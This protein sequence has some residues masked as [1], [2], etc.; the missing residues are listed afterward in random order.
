MMKEFIIEAL[1]KTIGEDEAIVCAREFINSFGDDEKKIKDAIDRR[2]LSEPLQYIIGEWDFYNCTFRLGDG[3]LCPRP[4]TEMLVD[5]ALDFIGDG[6]S[7]VLDLC[8]GSGAIAISVAKNA[9]DSKVI[10][11]EK[12]PA[13]Y[14]YL[15]QNIALNGVKNVKVFNDDILTGCDYFFKAKAPAF[16]LILSN[17]PYVRTGDIDDLDLEVQ[18]EPRLAL[19]GGEDGLVFYRA[20][21]DRWLPLLKKGGRMVLECG[22]D[23]A[24]E[25]IA[26]FEQKIATSCG[27]IT[28]KLD[29]NGL[30]RVIS[31]EIY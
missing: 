9:P 14:E 13:A 11:I 7:V 10:A 28:K 18:H 25:I 2:L 1:S 16:D 12:S 24:D 26:I 20:L 21:C 30:Y 31:V 29:F 4:E 23:Q 27:K 6:S 8:S 19:D 5:E 15:K 17:P 3:V 22:E